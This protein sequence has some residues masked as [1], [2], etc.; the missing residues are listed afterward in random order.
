[1]AAH[2]LSKIIHLLVSHVVQLSCKLLFRQILKRLQESPEGRNVLN[3]MPI[4][5]GHTCDA[6]LHGLM[7][8]ADAFHRSRRR[9]SG[10][11]THEVIHKRRF[12]RLVS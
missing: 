4:A 7:Q 5:S 6:H 10:A 1:M 8:F 2:R 9:P 3:A 11:M 12:S